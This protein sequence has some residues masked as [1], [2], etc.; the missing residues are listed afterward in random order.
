[1]KLEVVG[2]DGFMMNFGEIHRLGE[3]DREELGGWER[4]VVN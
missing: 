1:L 4:S 3:E 2:I